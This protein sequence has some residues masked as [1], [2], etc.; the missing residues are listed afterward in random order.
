[1]DKW[2]SSAACAGEDQKW[3]LEMVQP[4]G[5]WETEHE[6]ILVRWR[7]KRRTGRPEGGEEVYTGEW[8]DES[9]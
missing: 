3:Y 4:D 9:G 6:D 1:M 8:Y 7:E 2:T 5:E